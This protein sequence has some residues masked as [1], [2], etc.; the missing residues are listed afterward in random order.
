MKGYLVQLLEMK[1]D[2]VLHH[3]RRVFN[4]TKVL[5]NKLLCEWDDEE[6]AGIHVDPP[7]FLNPNICYHNS[8]T[9]LKR[10]TKSSMQRTL[11]G[12]FPKWLSGCGIVLSTMVYLGRGVMVSQVESKN[13]RLK[14]W[15]LRW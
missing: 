8:L 2:V 12:C 1:I 13:L 14:L 4:Y 9:L 3:G 15:R 7:T 5:E 6:S 10:V 11:I